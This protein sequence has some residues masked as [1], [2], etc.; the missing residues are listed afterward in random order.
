MTQNELEQIQERYNAAYNT[1]LNLGNIGTIIKSTEANG[2][3]IHVRGIE[4]MRINDFIDAALHD[5][6]KQLVINALNAKREE[7]QK[8][9]DKL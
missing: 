2:L 4:Y 9:F 5:R 7:L 3:T 1:K 8:E 6:I